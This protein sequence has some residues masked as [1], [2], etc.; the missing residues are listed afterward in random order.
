VK[1]LD[2]E[3]KKRTWRRYLAVWGGAVAVGLL[4]GAGPV[5][6][7]GA[8]ATGSDG[9]HTSAIQAVF[10]QTPTAADREWAARGNQDQRPAAERMVAPASSVRTTFGFC[11][12]GGGVNC[13]VDGDTIWFQ[14]QKVRIAEIDAPET[15][16]FRCPEEKALGDRAAR[17][18]IQLLNGGSVSLQPIDRDEDVYGRKLRIV[19]INGTSVGATLV[20][21]GL[22]RPYGNGRKPWC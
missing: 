6:L 2:V 19:L 3:R 21:E 20:G 12:T 14:G 7:K 5:M 18:L 10:E 17:R 11:H 9:K 22:A 1:L 4:V 8:P 16:D 13:V 15:H